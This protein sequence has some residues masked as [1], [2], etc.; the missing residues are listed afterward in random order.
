MCKTQNNSTCIVFGYGEN[1]YCSNDIVLK[2][3][4]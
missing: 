2:A 1:K 3:V 4:F